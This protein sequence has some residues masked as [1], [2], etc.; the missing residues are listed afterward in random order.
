MITREI[1]S[2]LN[3]DMKKKES[4]TYYFPNLLTEQDIQYLNRWGYEVTYTTVEQSHFLIDGTY[5][6]DAY[7]LTKRKEKEL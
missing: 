6:H 5:T 3:K 7:I 2:Y 1:I 4:E